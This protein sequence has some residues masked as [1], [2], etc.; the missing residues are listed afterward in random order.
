MGLG[1]VGLA[2]RAEAGIGKGCMNGGVDRAQCQNLTPVIGDDMGRRR[3]HSSHHHHIYKI[4][5]R[6]K[7][8]YNINKHLS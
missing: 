5:Y 2:G 4:I 8:S 1:G 6:S 3:T 7:N